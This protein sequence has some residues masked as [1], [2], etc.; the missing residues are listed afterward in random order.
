MLLR[1]TSQTDV[2]L[3]Q[4]VKRPQTHSIVT[5]YFKKPPPSSGRVKF[6]FVLQII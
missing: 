6:P 4:S 2:E 5:V 3:C 1:P